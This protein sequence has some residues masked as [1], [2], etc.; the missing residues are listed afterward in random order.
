MAESVI[1]TQGT[2][3]DTKTIVTV[4]LLIFFFPVGFIMMWVWTHW[5]TWV[6][7]LISTIVG[8]YMLF[9]F[10]IVGFFFTV[11]IAAILAPSKEDNTDKQLPKVQQLTPTPTPFKQTIDTSSWKTYENKQ[12]RFSFKYPSDWTITP[13]KD[14]NNIVGIKTQGLQG[15]I[16]MLWGSGFGGMC[17][18][19][20]EEIQIQD[21]TLNACH[22]FGVGGIEAWEQ[23]SKELA[24]TSFQARAYANKPSTE[25]RDTILA[26]LSTFKFTK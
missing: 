13:V 17:P 19:G 18:Q 11:F 23:I 16:T 1:P 20:Y 3:D 6:K 12:I 10:I 4:L 9:I 26:I 7:L 25:N 15:D 5:P 2:S 24:T 14:A 8:L 22:N 21:E